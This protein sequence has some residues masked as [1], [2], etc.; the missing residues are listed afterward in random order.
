MS[1]ALPNVVDGMQFMLGIG[2]NVRNKAAT[3]KCRN[4]PNVSQAKTLN[5]DIKYLPINPVKGKKVQEMCFS[6]LFAM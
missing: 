5:F 2:E 3:L 4:L 1:A 6:S